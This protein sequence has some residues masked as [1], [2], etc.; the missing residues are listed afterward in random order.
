ML[1]NRS[2]QFPEKILCI[3]CIHVNKKMDRQACNSCALMFV[4]PVNYGTV[5]CPHRVDRRD[6]GLLTT[7]DP[8]HYTGRFGS[9]R[10]RSQWSPDRVYPFNLSVP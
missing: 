2:R 5:F 8:L 9:A 10:Q 1:R 4:F 7:P 3:L 6:A